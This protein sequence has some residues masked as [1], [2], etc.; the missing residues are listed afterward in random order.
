MAEVHPRLAREARTIAAMIHLYCREQHGAAGE[1]CPDCRELLAYA[2][3]RLAKCP[4]QEGKTTCANC[5]VHCYK[6]AMRERI[7][8]IMRYAGPRMLYRHP[9][10]A[11]R[12]LLDGRRKV[13]TRPPRPASRPPAAQP[14]D[15]S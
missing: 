3:L 14:A 13:A 15:E 1:L 9:I 10:L 2:D 4:F 8:V 11:I 12:H 5:R 6:P 7:R